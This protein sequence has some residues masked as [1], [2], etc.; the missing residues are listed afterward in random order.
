[1]GSRKQEKERLRQERI[2]AERRASADARK[3]LILGYVVAG[4]LGVAV[5][6]GAIYAIASSG[7]DGGSGG[8]GDDSDNVATEFGFLPDDLPVDEREGTPPPEVVNGDLVGASNV[9]GCDLQLDLRDEGNAHFDD[10]DKVVE[11]DTNPPASG[12][13][14]A[15]NGPDEPGSGA[16]AD[17]AFLQMPPE[18]RTIHSLEHGRI[19]VQYSPDLPEEDQLALKGLFDEQPEGIL[20][21]P[22]PE[23]PY[24][25]AATAWTQL[26][27]CDTFEGA[28]T[29]DVIRAFRDQY[30]GR[31]PEPVTFDPDQLG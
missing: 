8:G 19:V 3:R 2:E 29:L 27:G 26:V 12:D 13:H 17:G 18:N 28:A 20:L 6:G 4:I 14:F 24:E 9:A 16:L 15:A 31:G 21:F 7:D 1:M 22:N 10:V 25:V 23:M 5:V 30:L 11:R